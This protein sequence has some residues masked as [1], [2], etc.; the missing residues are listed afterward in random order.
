MNSS[1]QPSICITS[2][3]N[4]NLADYLVEIPYNEFQQLQQQSMI[5]GHNVDHLNYSIQQQPL[6][7]NSN[8]N[9]IIYPNTSPI[10]MTTIATTTNGLNNLSIPGSVQQQ[11]QQQRTC[12]AMTKVN[13]NHMNMN[14]NPNF[15]FQR[16]QQQQYHHHHS[17]YPSNYSSTTMIHPNNTMNINESNYEQN[18][19]FEIRKTCSLQLKELLKSTLEKMHSTNSQNC[20]LFLSKIDSLEKRLMNRLQTIETKLANCSRLFDSLN[21]DFMEHQ[22]IST[23]TTTF[24]LKTITKKWHDKYTIIPDEI[25]DNDDDDDLTESNSNQRKV[26]FKFPCPK[27][28]FGFDEKHLLDRHIRTHVPGRDHVCEHCGNL[29]SSKYKLNCHKVRHTN[30]SRFKIK[31]PQCD[32]SSVDKQTLKRHILIHSDEKNFHC[33]H[34]ERRFRTNEALKD[35]QIIHLD[36]SPFRCQHCTSRFRRSDY[37]K[38]HILKVHSSKE[39]SQ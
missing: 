6:Q 17:I 38:M 22:Q 9:Y 8:S 15:Q 7:M 39:K 24:P 34:C 25:Q 4:Q 16:Q 2:S 11:Q 14:K 32:Y 12:S 20:Q 23:T 26:N 19:E 3:N 33:N 29:F 31:C 10:M 1:T 27:C 30:D 28:L 21:E 5:S 13:M 37:L 35:H 18:D 36:Q